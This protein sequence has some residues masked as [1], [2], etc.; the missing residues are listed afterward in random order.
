MII[1][2]TQ[3]GQKDVETGQTPYNHIWMG[4]FYLWSPLIEYFRR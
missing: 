4:E 2:M 3:E 1:R